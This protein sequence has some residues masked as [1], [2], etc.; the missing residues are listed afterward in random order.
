MPQKARINS[1]ASPA[2]KKIDGIPSASKLIILPVDLLK[3]KMQDAI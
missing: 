1:A 3:L 2:Q